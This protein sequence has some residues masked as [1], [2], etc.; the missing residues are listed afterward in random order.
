MFN[1]YYCAEALYAL[2][3]VCIGRQ[4]KNLSDGAA[5]I[6]EQLGAADS[7]D[8]VSV[9]EGEMAGMIARLVLSILAWACGAFVLI[10][11]VLKGIAWMQQGQPE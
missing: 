7:A 3:L 5:R 8:G 1:I 2:I 4:K 10:V 6:L 9:P 11:A